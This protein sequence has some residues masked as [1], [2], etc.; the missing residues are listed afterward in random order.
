M[1]ILV[2]GD[3]GVGGGGRGGRAGGG[4][5]IFSDPWG[6]FFTS[7]SVYMYVYLHIFWGVAQPSST[8]FLPLLYASFPDFICTLVFRPITECA[9][10]ARYL[11]FRAPSDRSE[12]ERAD[13]AWER[14]YWYMHL[15]MRIRMV[16][17]TCT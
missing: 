8:I 6:K 1:V 4:R 14:G 13:R 16:M 2:G 5:G 15:L 7:D 12:Y 9:Q 11:P 17:Y 3:W 10:K